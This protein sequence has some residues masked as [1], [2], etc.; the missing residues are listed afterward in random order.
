MTNRA[1]IRFKEITSQQSV[2][3][4]SNLSDK[5]AA[6]HP[7]RI[8]NQI[9][10]QLSI[11]DILSSYKGGGTSSFHPRV[12]IKVLFYSYFCNIYSCRKI[13]KLL[14]ENIHFMW[15][16]GNATPNFRTINNF[17]GQRLKGK[18]QRLF[19]ELVRL[20][21]EMGYVSL[22]IQYIDGTKIEAA[23]NKY[24]F[25][26]KGSV[27]KNKAKLEEKI[28]AVLNSIDTAIDDDHKA[29]DQPELKEIN[30]D[31]L[32]EKIEQL[33]A[34]LA[35]LNKKEQKRLKTLEEDHLP[36]L[37]KYELQLKI[38]GNRNSY[39]KTDPSATFMR[40]KDDHMMNGQLKPAY[41]VQIST[42][43]QILTNFS[44]HQRPGDTA[45][46]TPHLEQFE[47][48]HGKQSQKAVADAGYGSEE[49]YEY[50]A[51]K[52]IEAFYK[53]NYFHKEQKQNNKNNP[54]LPNNLFLSNEKSFI[55]C[56]M[57]QKMHLIGT[58][59]R[60]SDLGYISEIHRYQALNCKGCPM[61]GQCHR[62]KDN[63]IIELNHQL[64]TYRQQAKEKLLSE[65]GLYHRSQRPIEPEAV[66]GQIKFNN[67]FNRFTLKGLDKVEVEFGLVAISHNL[68]KI[69]QIMA[70]YQDKTVYVITYVELYP[71]IK[72][73]HL[74]NSN[75][76]K[77]IEELKLVA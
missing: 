12:M 68:R 54:F 57:G 61:R 28:K 64:I 17:R 55:V 34:K 38:L 77:T 71:E 59:K 40:M 58:Y 13:E 53:Y 8:V 23:S 65:E 45:T 18:I 27:E 56:P 75:T 6:N 2:L 4:P 7:V 72:Q 24:S 51:N 16:S 3:F 42:E 66:F 41:N 5:I 60:K 10:D 52:D 43:N 33:N 50:A 39:S 19:A 1:K 25:V 48:L 76:E 11:D 37:L 14:K 73:K 67:K 9:V 15:L 74:V 49:N 32:H 36:R 35:T 22:D 46:L 20:M 29:S 69:A 26:W 70:P 44:L 47:E 21:A 63:R 62:S 30:S 31:E